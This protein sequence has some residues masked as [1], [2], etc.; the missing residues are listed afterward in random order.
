M[1]G[2]QDKQDGW[3]LL[4]KSVARPTREGSRRVRSARAAVLWRRAARGPGLGGAPMGRGRG[5]EAIAS[6]SMAAENT[7][8]TVSWSLIKTSYS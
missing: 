6:T 1:R 7:T 2:G 8:V 4:P 3:E 5:A